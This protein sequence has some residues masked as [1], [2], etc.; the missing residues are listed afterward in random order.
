MRYMPTVSSHTTD[1]IQRAQFLATRPTL[2]SKVIVRADRRSDRCLLLY[3]EGGLELSDAA[4]TIVRCCT[5]AYEIR[6]IIARL[7]DRY[8]PEHCEV[9]ERDVC[10][11]LDRLMDRGLV[12]VR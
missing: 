2:D 9:I 6:E 10:A 7:V 1:R 4:E 12:H 8:G 5:G 11:F 3:P